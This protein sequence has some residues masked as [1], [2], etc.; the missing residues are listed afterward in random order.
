MY[1]FVCHIHSN[2][3][4]ICM[5]VC[6]HI[7]SQ[8]QKKKKRRQRVTLIEMMQRDPQVQDAGNN[9]PAAPTVLP[10]LP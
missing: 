2:V 10:S 1:A 8:R 7:V 9:A 3:K 6:V 5:S 4:G